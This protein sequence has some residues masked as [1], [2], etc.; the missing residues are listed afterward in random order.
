M[1]F[2]WPQEKVA[3][4]IVGNKQRKR[5]DVHSNPDFVVVTA[6]CAEL[7]DYQVF[8]RIAKA[9]CALLARKPSERTSEWFAAHH[10][11]FDGMTVTF[12]SSVR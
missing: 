9:L 12:G 4:D 11:L 2:V 3:F 7:D 5:F 6:T 10:A 8:H 1:S